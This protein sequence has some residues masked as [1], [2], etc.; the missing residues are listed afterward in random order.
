VGE[1][2][3]GETPEAVVRLKLVVAGAESFGDGGSIG[4]TNLA[5]LTSEILNDLLGSLRSTPTANLS[6]LPGLAQQQWGG[7]R[8]GQ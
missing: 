5:D 2:T 4:F 3:S 7:L 8:S 1:I 6:G